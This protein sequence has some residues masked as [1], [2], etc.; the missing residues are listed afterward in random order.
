MCP[1]PGVVGTI[2]SMCLRGGDG[3]GTERCAPLLP[4]AHKEDNRRLCLLGPKS[5]PY[6]QP[7]RAT[8]RGTGQRRQHCHISNDA[9]KE[10]G[11]GLVEPPLAGCL[12]RRGLW[13]SVL[14]PRKPLARPRRQVGADLTTSRSRRPLTSQPPII[15]AA[16]GEEKPAL[17]SRPSTSQPCAAGPTLRHHAPP[18]T[19]RLRPGQAGV[20]RTCGAPGLGGAPPSSATPGHRPGRQG[21]RQQQRRWVTVA[22]P[23]QDLPTPA[24][25][26][27]RRWCGVVAVAVAVADVSLPSPV[28]VGCWWACPPLVPQRHRRLST[29][30]C[31]SSGGRSQGRWRPSRPP[32]RWRPWPLASSR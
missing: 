2:Q 14:L 9:S 13:P 24:F 28:P 32:R 3:G 8:A 12:T 21:C 15:P 22:G 5:K 6:L 11:S 31:S 27:L 1:L 23:W 26:C 7:G 19:M 20:V 4:G 16:G 25:V 18:R 17:P 10:E 29:W 30:R